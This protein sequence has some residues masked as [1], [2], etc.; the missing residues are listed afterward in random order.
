MCTVR[1]ACLN[2]TKKQKKRDRVIT[3]SNTLRI[4]RR[5]DVRLDGAMCM[6]TMLASWPSCCCTVTTGCTA[7]YEAAAVATQDFAKCARHDTG[8]N[9]G[10]S[11]VVIAGITTAHCSGRRSGKALKRSKVVR[12]SGDRGHAGVTPS[13]QQSALMHSF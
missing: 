8:V 11:G 6:P 9:N 2:D 10:H 3:L 1:A 5:I 4:P 13:S 7:V 12:G